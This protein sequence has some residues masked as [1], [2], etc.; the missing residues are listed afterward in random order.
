[1]KYETFQNWLNK[2]GFSLST[3]NSQTRMGEAG[4]TKQFSK[5]AAGQEQRDDLAAWVEVFVCE[6]FSQ[7]HHWGPFTS[8]CFARLE[9]FC[10]D[11]L[12]N[13]KLQFIAG[14]EWKG[15]L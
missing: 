6:K 2:N 9:D 8:E 15:Y 14:K 3:V 13:G 4:E 7:V 5:A 11:L 12:P 1:M 10:E